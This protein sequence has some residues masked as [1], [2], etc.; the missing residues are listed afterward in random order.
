M[1]TKKRNP[2]VAA[3]RTIAFVALF[4]AAGYVIFWVFTGRNNKRVYDEAA[5]RYVKIVAAEESGEADGG[6]GLDDLVKVDHPFSNHDF[7][8]TENRGIAMPKLSNYGEK[9]KHIL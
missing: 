4:F 8:L 9:R 6:E 7:I 1:E 2:L 5:A 3:I